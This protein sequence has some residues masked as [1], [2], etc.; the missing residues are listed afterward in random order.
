MLLALLVRQRAP[1]FAH[2]LLVHATRVNSIHSRAVAQS[3]AHPLPAHRAV[4]L[5]PTT[6]HLD[7]I[8]PVYAKQD[9][10]IEPIDL[11]LRV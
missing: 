5:E 11:H 6:P 7:I 1:L 10:N 8:D 4:L 2:T 3:L 9:S